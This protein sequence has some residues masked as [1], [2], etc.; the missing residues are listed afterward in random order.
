MHVP[1]PVCMRAA[2]LSLHDSTGRPLV[3][4]A[5][6]EARSSVSATGRRRVTVDAAHE[7][8]PRGAVLLDVHQR[9]QW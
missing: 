4:V 7:R 5:R 9:R 1:V 8:V 6:V 2:G 3:A